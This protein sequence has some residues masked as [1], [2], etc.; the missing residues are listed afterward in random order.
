MCDLEVIIQS[1]LKCILQ[2]NNVI[3]KAHYPIKNIF[4]TF[5][6]HDYEFYK[7]LYTCYVRPVLE[8]ATQV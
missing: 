7:N 8:S 3:K 4:N 6:D 1:H 5:K 2:Y